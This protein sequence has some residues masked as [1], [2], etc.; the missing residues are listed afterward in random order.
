[1]TLPR[2]DGKS[3]DSTCRSLGIYAKVL[4]LGTAFFFFL[5]HLGNQLPYGQAK[6]RF[7]D[8]IAASLLESYVGYASGY[9]SSWA[10]CQASLSVIAGALGEEVAGEK[11]SLVDAVL[12]LTFRREFV[13][14]GDYC[15]ELRGTSFGTVTDTARLKPRYWWGSKALFAIALRWVSVVDCFHFIQF[16]TYGA[17]LLLAGALLPLGWRA[18][19]VA[20]PLIVFGS[21]FSGIRYFSGVENGLPHMWAVLAAAILALLLRWRGGARAVPLFCFVAGMVSSYLWMFDGHNFLSITLIGLIGWLGHEGLNVINRAW[22]VGGYMALYIIG[23][24]LCFMSGQ[25]VKL[26]VHE[27]AAAD[28]IYYHYDEDIAGKPAHPGKGVAESFFAQSSYHLGRV[29]SPEAT[30][31]SGRDI[32]T[33]W[34]LLSI[35]PVVGI[36]ITILSA[37]ALLGAVLFASFRSR[38]G[39]PELVWNILWLVGVM[40]LACVHFVLPTNHPF[41]TA[42]FMFVPL[43]FCWSCF[44]LAITYSQIPQWVSSAADRHPWLS[45]LRQSINW[46]YAAGI[47]LLAFAI[48][49]HLHNP[50]TNLWVD[51]DYD[52]ESLIARSQDIGDPIVQQRFEVYYDEDKLIYVTEECGNDNTAPNIFLHLHPVNLGDLSSDRKQFGFDNLDFNFLRRMDRG[53]REGVAVCVVAR[54]LPDYPIAQIS[55][56]QYIHKSGVSKTIWEASFLLEVAELRSS[57]EKLMTGEPIIRSGFDV[58]ADEGRLVYVKEQCTETDTVRPFFLH[59]F[60]VDQGDL[61]KFRRRYDFDNMDFYFD[62]YGFVDDGRCVAVRGLP[63]YLIARVTT[64]QYTAEGQL[65]KAEFNIHVPE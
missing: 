13:P 1:M 54:D 65:W 42:R 62:H 45:R 33:F 38:R 10:Y 3:L 39:R 47:A 16:A 19:L 29:I 8:D 30:D 53:E 2:L 12:P 52:A 18:L 56:G 36:A 11:R 32:G 37:L 9:S 44:I 46:R 21:F 60:P 35:S 7:S 24:V 34:E 4:I 49:L 57:Y 51:R 6:Q 41:R 48:A 27:Q 61:P 59:V 58:Y 14:S 43:A 22:R 31:A 5:H 20:S 26:I 15:V 40:L 23:F 50:P 63:D 28:G 64:G 17:Y 55:T 25:V